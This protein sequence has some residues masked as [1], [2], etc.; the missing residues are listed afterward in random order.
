MSATTHVDMSPGSTGDVLGDAWEEVFKN[1]YQE[2]L[3]EIVQRYP[4]EQNWVRVNYDDIFRV[5]VELSDAVLDDPKT[6]LQVG[7]IVLESWDF[8]TPG[9]GFD[10]QIEIRVTNLPDDE[11]YNPEDLRAED[12][13][14]YVGIKGSLS[15]ITQPTDYPTE[16]AFECACGRTQ[17]PVVV[18]QPNR[19][20]MQEPTDSCPHCEQKRNWYPTT[21]GGTWEDLSKVRIEQSI[22]QSKGN[23]GASI[24][25]I[26]VGSLV[27]GYGTELYARAGEDCVAYG[28]LERRQRDE[29]GSADLLFKQ[30]LDVHDI[31][32]NTDSD[33]VNPDD[34]RDRIKSVVTEQS[35]PVET[36]VENIAP[37]LKTTDRWERA[38][39]LA[40]AYLFKA[41]RIHTDSGEIYRGDIHAGIIGDPGIGK[42]VLN[43]AIERI[44]PR[45]ERRSATGISSD[46]GL[47][48][49]AIKDDFGEGEYTLEPG[50][51]VRA[52]G[53]H[54]VIDEIDKGPSD[55]EKINDALEG[56]QRVTVDKG[57]KHAEF[58]TR[59][60]LWAT[61]NPEDGRF[62]RG[63]HAD[64]LP[65]QVNIDTSLRDRFDG[66]VLIP[67]EQDTEHDSDVAGH[68][69]DAYEEASN[70][71]LENDILKRDVSLDELQAWVM[72]GQE[73]DPALT[74]PAKS[75]I[76]DYYT[77]LRSRNDD[78]DTFVTTA[79]GVES[80]IRFAGA[81][82]RLYLSETI[83]P[84]HAELATT[85]MD[86]IIGQ[87]YDPESGE[88]LDTHEW[89][90]ESS[91]QQSR[92][93]RL[94]NAIR[95]DALTVDE[96]Q[97]ETGLGTETITDE[98]EMLKKKGEA[99]EPETGRYRLV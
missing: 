89:S 37:Q 42:S 88:W 99:I 68:I 91:S 38:V 49:A 11:I 41:P 12:G 92:K 61:G 79:R 47:T 40:T 15:K 27:E 70:E 2:K 94:K 67:D 1:Y 3:E 9:V 7:E 90:A 32:F 23:E 35:N 97:D 56:D 55:L 69:L 81:F 29:R 75:E 44:S 52:N 59:T 25:G 13:G 85:L 43:R 14:K 26:V 45:A 95:M 63:D 73:I 39:W 58:A 84:V 31:D 71:D 20:E 64:P 16:L 98:I 72:L 65:A 24:T 18:P 74:E 86:K 83:D 62:N 28:I 5:N 60:A 57:G 93:E 76:Q 87:Y 77:E 6:A 50:I 30:Y 96:I 21:D 8:P 46:V 51:L 10:E 4:S 33:T 17:T 78:S 66:L 34:Y 54:A 36:F 48:A 80:L 19:H 82:A 53:G 22:D